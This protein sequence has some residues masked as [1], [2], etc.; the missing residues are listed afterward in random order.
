[1]SVWDKI[2][3]IVT[4]PDEDYYDEETPEEDIPS[5]DDV[6]D[7]D[8]T[9]AYRPRVKAA[10]ETASRVRAPRD[11]RKVVDIHTTAKLQVV[12]RTPERFEDAIE[13]ADDLNEKRTVVLNLEKC[14]R[15]SARRLVDFLSGAA[16]ANGGQPKKIALNIYIFTPYNV[17][18]MG[19]LL[20]DLESSGYFFG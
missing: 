18:V 19:D 6:A 2:K 11:D 15:D 12:L 16:Y 17:D 3:N 4:V 7:E 8:A 1:M 5:F 20:D 14:D 10:R 13:I 9:R